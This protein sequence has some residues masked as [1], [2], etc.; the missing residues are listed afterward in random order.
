MKL[1]AMHQTNMIKTTLGTVTSILGASVSWI[2][3]IEEGV[4]I[5]AGIIA[6]IAGIYAIMN[7][8]ADLKVKNQNYEKNKSNTRTASTDGRHR[9]LHDH[10]D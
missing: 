5:G 1:K 3:A 8:R 2:H 4:R 7:Y 9:R 6:I 10:E